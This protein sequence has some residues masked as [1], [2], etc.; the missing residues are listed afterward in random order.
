MELISGRGLLI[1]CTLFLLLTV[2]R[3][4]SYQ[5]GFNEGA[6]MVISVAN[7]V[8]QEHIQQAREW[9]KQSPLVR[10]VDNAD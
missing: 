2:T 6:S 5:Q 10:E 4:C 7:E 8:N 3:S 9:L 1:A